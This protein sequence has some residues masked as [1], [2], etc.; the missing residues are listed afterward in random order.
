M[1]SSTSLHYTALVED[2]E[3][4]DMRDTLIC[5][6]L[7]VST[8]DIALF[9]RLQMKLDLDLDKA[10]QEA[11]REQQI[12]LKST[13]EHHCPSSHEKSPITRETG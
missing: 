4:G 1:Q 9:E 5:D 10:K 7:A 12:I 2:C 6:R 11:I 13:P 3:F 8:R